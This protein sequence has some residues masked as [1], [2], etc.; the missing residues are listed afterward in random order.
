MSKTVEAIYENGVFRL[1]EPVSLPEGEHGQVAVPELSEELV[2]A[3]ADMTEEERRI[4]DEAT[5][6]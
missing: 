5:A 2:H 1:L 3:L 6:R 4:F